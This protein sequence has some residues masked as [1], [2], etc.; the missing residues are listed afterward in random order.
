MT[1]CASDKNQKLPDASLDNATVGLFNGMP[2]VIY[3]R[4]SESPSATLDFR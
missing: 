4:S 2:K 3:R 1:Y